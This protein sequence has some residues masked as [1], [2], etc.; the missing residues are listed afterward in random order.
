MPW[1]SP[2][3]VCPVCARPI[4]LTLAGRLRRHGAKEPG[5]WPPENCAGTG[6]VPANDNDKEN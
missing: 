4:A 2:R 6:R 5:V 3:G 1:K